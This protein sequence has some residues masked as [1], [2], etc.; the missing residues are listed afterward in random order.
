MSFTNEISDQA[1]LQELGTRL[2][3]YRLNRNLTQGELSREAGVSMRTL[4]R[5]EHGQS[6]QLKNWLR[7]L[8]AFGLLENLDV[9]LPEPVVSPLQQAKML[10]KERKRAS[11]PTKQLGKTGPWTWGDEE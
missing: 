8:R 6:A 7:L 4:H 3:R 9:L 11:S 5:I 1:I 2:A 10:G